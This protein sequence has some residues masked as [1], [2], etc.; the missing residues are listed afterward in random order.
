M[1]VTWLHISDLH[2]KA[3]ESH[4]RNV[5]L[6]ALV[7]SVRGYREREKRAPDMIFATGD[8]AHSGQPK[9]YEVATLFFDQLLAAAGL[10][11]SHL[12]VGL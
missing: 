6:G 3:D 8:I 1:S 2:L 4:D 5:V 11:R 12:Y 9:E 7:K 10:G